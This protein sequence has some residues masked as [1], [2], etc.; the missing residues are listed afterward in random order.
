MHTRDAQ[1]GGDLLQTH[2]QGGGWQP[3]KGLAVAVEGQELGEEDG[4]EVPLFGVGHVEG[5]DWGPSG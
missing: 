4:L 5:E 3:E 1:R 2:R